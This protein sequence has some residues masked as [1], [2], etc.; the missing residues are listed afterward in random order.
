MKPKFHASAAMEKAS[1]TVKQG[2]RVRI[3]PA[4]DTDPMAQ[5]WAGRLCTV[6]Q[7]ITH[8]IGDHVRVEDEKGHRGT[9]RRCDLEECQ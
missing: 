2:D 5:E 6:R 9:F 7:I 4:D 3:K 8:A 1:L